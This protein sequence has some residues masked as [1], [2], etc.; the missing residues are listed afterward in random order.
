MWSRSDQVFRLVRAYAGLRLRVSAGV[1]PASPGLDRVRAHG[2]T[3]ASVPGQRG[4]R[5]VDPPGGRASVAA[6]QPG[7]TGAVTPSD[8]DLAALG[9]RASSG[10]TRP[11]HDRGARPPLRGRR[12]LGE[13]TGWLAGV[14][15]P[16]TRAPAQ[17]RCVVFVGRPARPT[18]R[19][20]PPAST[21]GWRDRVPGI[22]PAATR[23]GGV[24]P[25][26]PPPTRRSTAAPTCSSSSIGTTRPRRRC[27][28]RPDR[29]RAGRAAAPGRSRHRH[30]GLDRARGATCAT[31]GD[32]A[33][34]CGDDAGR[35][36]H[37]AG[38]RRPWPRRSDWSC[39]LPRGGRRPCWTGR[40][41]CGRPA[42]PRRPATSAAVVAGRRQL[43]RPRCTGGRAGSS[44]YSRCW[45]SPPRP[46]T[47]SRACSPS[48]CCTRRPC[49]RRADERAAH[50]RPARGRDLGGP[51]RRRLGVAPAGHRH[52]PVLRGAD[53]PAHRTRRVLLRPRAV[54][55][56]GAAPAG[57]A[58]QPP[59]RPAFGVGGLALLV[60]LLVL[61]GIATFVTWQIST[62]AGELG[63]QV[64]NW[65]RRHGVGCA[66]ARCT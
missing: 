12:R 25:G 54:L 37:R 47:A 46:A 5:H 41:P 39:A 29:G 49:G 62:H 63:D 1:R 10:R 17:A 51:R 50:P 34:G 33:A 16:T 52:R 14:Q 42:L 28:S 19:A 3:P 21:W 7:H 9:R 43:R 2:T 26:W 15:E 36:A 11:R 53:L 44:T 27:R 45:I 61:A 65:S 64:S 30:R 59:A 31:P 6:R 18:P 60:G 57:T 4:P 56:R 38:A 13:L 22:D 55:H 20:W 48:R 40:R 32:R 66:P 8:L 58:V 23:A 24:A 35:A